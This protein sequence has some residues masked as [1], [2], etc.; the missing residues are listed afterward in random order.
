MVRGAAPGDIDSDG[1]LDVLVTRCGEAALLQRNEG[2]NE[3]ASISLALVGRASNRDA[4]GARVTLRS[5]E[6]VSIAEVKTGVS[7]LSQGSLEIHFGLGERD[8]VDSLEFRWPS[9]KR[10]KIENVP[11][12]R[13]LV[14]EGVGRIGA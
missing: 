2:G 5:G 9:G 3:K 13:H 12:G 7:Y 6:R 1:D 11:A 4:V 14:V 10:E 8:R